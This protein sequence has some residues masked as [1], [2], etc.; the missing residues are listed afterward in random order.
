LI[1]NAKSS[2]S[3]AQT[4]INAIQVMADLPGALSSERDAI[5]Q[6][7]RVDEAKQT[8]ESIYNDSLAAL[9]AGDV[10]TA[11]SS[12][13]MLR[14]LRRQLAVSYRLQIVSRPDEYSGVWR[15]PDA[16]PDAKN[17]YL[18]VEALG[19]DGI[20]LTLP[21]LNEEDGKTYDVNKWGVRVSEFQFTQVGADKQDD[22]IIQDRV[23]G[24]KRTGFLEPE[25]SIQTSGETITSW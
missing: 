5:L 3:E 8:A 9:R 10:S 11:Q 16:N 4:T 7:A 6:I 15:I 18:V 17:Y 23:V 25:Y 12:Y 1:E 2:L 24:S 19:A 21:Q 14:E 22:G 20:P 13:S